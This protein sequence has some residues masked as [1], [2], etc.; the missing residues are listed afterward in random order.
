MK[1]DVFERLQK[2]LDTDQLVAL[3]TVVGGFAAGRQRLLRPGAKP[4][5]SLG[6]EP[7][8]HEADRLATEA[9]RTFASTR[10]TIES[11]DAVDLFCEVYPPAPKLVMIGAVHVAI[12]LGR[13]AKELG[14]RT[15]VIDPRTAF[16]TAER[17]SHIDRLD[18]RWPKEALADQ[19]L[20]EG[21]A[22]ATLSHDMKLDLPALE[23]ALESPARYIG[24]LGSKRTHAKR[25]AELEESGFSPEQLARIHSPI[26][27]DLGGRRAQEIALAI[28]AEIVAVEHGG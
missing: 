22:V 7:L 1:N 14:Y 28:M 5:G 17:F 15:I 20:D 16:A 23:A 11:E 27:L 18:P 8:D 12:H 19:K 10:V 24:A 3:V 2:H 6:S 21:T 25:V 4:F 9:F 13:F 26:G